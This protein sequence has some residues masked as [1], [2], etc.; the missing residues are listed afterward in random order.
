MAVSEVGGKWATDG[1]NP[2]GHKIVFYSDQPGGPWAYCDVTDSIHAQ[3][4]NDPL[5]TVQA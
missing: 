1:V 5:V 4:P 2:Q 3:V